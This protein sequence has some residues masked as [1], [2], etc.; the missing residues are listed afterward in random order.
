MSPQLVNKLNN[1]LKTEYNGIVFKNWGS[2]MGMNA[3]RGICLSKESKLAEI[4]VGLVA[5]VGKL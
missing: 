5:F 2:P 4:H 3:H 1:I